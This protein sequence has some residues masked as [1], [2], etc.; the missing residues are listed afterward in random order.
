[1][2]YRSLYPATEE[3]VDAAIQQSKLSITPADCM[4]AFE[5]TRKLYAACLAMED[6]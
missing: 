5:H 4:H 6:L 1:M 2:A 3:A